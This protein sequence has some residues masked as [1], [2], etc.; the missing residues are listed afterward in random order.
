MA[1]RV[2]SAVKR[3]YLEPKSSK[4]LETQR[5]VL[6]ALA[7]KRKNPRQAM[8]VI[9]RQAGTTLR[10]MK[11]YIP[12]ALEIR[13]GRIDV[14]PTDR[15]TR[16]LQM[17]TPEGLQDV[18]VHSSRDASRIAKHHNAVQRALFTFWTDTSR[19][20]RF[21]G[22][23][24]KTAGKTYAFATDPRVIDRLARAGGVHFLDIYGNGGSK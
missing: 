8:S 2:P 11:R 22:K 24:I 3:L 15:I 19:L 23:S 5:R 18:T 14:K 13:G 12:G 21:A 4:Q 9:A 16:K 1:S 10:T 6:D 20:D 17:L 7:E